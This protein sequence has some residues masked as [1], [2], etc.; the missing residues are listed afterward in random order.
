MPNHSL[1]NLSYEIGLIDIHVMY[2]SMLV[3]CA[4][5]E[6]PYYMDPNNHFGMVLKFI[7]KGITC[8]I[9]SSA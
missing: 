7:I 5:E 9:I 3:Q 2:V 6:I 4:P 8:T 1:I